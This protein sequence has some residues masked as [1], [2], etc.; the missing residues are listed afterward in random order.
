LR[1]KR[2]ELS[3]LIVALEKK[4]GQ[5]RADLLHLDATLRLFDPNAEPDQIRP[6]RQNSRNVWFRPGECVRLVCDM[7]RGSTTPLTTGEICRRLMAAKGIPA[8]DERTRDL[9]EKTVHGR[10]RQQ[11][12]QTLERSVVNGVTCWQVL[13]YTPRE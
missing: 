13:A 1:D 7:L 10:L 3:G 8:T 2:A 4:V 5:H 6:R 12:G 9:M 11:V